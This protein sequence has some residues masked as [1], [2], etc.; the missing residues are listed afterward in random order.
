MQ[1]VP[2]PSC[3]KKETV[4]MDILLTSN[5]GGRNIILGNII[6]G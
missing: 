6:L 3:A 4:D 2:E 1:R 5:N